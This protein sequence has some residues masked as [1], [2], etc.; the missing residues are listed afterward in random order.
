MY[1][2][3]YNSLFKLNH[4]WEQSSQQRTLFLPIHSELLGIQYGIDN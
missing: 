2:Y 1:M 4:L 3:V